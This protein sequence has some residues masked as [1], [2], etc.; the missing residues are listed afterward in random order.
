MKS[1]L[2]G[3]AVRDELLGRPVH[4]RD[5]VV[6]G[7]SPEELLS[8]GYRQVGRDF[9]VFLHP[10]SHEEYALARRERKTEPGYSGFEVDAGPEVTLE[11]D[12]ARRDLTIN[13][14]ARDDQG[15]LFD[16]HGGQKDLKQRTL[17]HI[18]VAFAEDPGRILRVA[19]FAARY[20][21]LGFKVAGETRELMRQ[22]GCSGEVDALTPER[23]WAETRKAL[24]EESPSRYIAELRECGAL[25]KIFPEVDALFGV[26]QPLQYH[27]EGDTGAH[28][29]LALDRAAVLCRADSSAVPAA[30]V[31]FAV[32]THDLGKGLTPRQDWPRHIGHEAAGVPLV[33]ALCA[34][35][36]VPRRS[37]EVALL[38][39]K[40]HLHAHRALE[41]KPKTV[42][43]LFNALD[44]WRRSERLVPF[45]L[46]CRA[47]FQGRQGSAESPYPQAEYLTACA[48]AARGVDISVLIEHHAPGTALQK[49]IRGERLAAI[50][51]VTRRLPQTDKKATK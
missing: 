18:S 27:P 46:A 12:L 17:R 11:Q 33:D 23:V 36:R 40:W 16:P 25:A 30:D 6:V 20:A 4:E 19:R 35:L 38:V 31:V 42:L 47:D 15:R 9:P 44:L 2:V 32:L 45:L 34:R 26:P 22:M 1:Y 5:W 13:A 41:A 14:L 8:A 43:K 37:R 24:A 39:C 48:E 49:A 50:R 10:T 29:L 51:A 21:E 7:G 3:G 28:L